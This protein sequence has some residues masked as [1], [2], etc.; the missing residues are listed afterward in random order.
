MEL[1]YLLY[2]KQELEKNGDVSRDLHILFQ[3]LQK[4]GIAVEAVSS[5]TL[6]VYM[7]RHNIPPEETLV[8]AATDQTLT[9]ISGFPAASIGYRRTDFTEEGL[10]G[11]DLLAE[12]FWEVDYRFLERVWQRKHR[13]PWR[14]LETE[15]TYLMEMTLSDLPGLYALYEGEKMTDFMEP[16][17]AWEEEAEYTK[18]Y[19]EHMYR[20]YGFGMWLLKDRNTHELIGRA[21]FNLFESGEGEPVLEMGYAIAASRQRKGYATEACTALIHYAKQ[22]ELGFDTLYCFVHKENRASIALLARLGFTCCGV[23]NPDGH[24]MYRYAYPLF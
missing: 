20:Y 5:Q 22:E 19:I 14:I 4:R 15:R 6:P 1:K 3:N 7:D 18:A 16:L 8:I 23:C 2:K 11:A 9:E 17:Y 24:K 13:I 12:G 10:Y 21:G